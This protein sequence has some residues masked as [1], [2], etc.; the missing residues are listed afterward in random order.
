[1]TTIEIENVSD[2][3]RSV[4]KVI[5]DSLTQTGQKGY[6]KVAGSVQWYLEK[7][8]DLIEEARSVQHAKLEAVSLKEVLAFLPEAKVA[9]DIPG[10]LRVRTSVLKGQSRLAAQC[11]TELDGIEGIDEVHVSALTGSVLFWYNTDILE[12]R[13]ALMQAIN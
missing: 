9:S 3:T 12:S 6:D 8:E 11:A 10:R 2:Q 7:W 5:P 1:M 4:S 13:D